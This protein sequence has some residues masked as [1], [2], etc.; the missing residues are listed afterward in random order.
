MTTRRLFL[1]KLASLAGFTLPCMIL[2]PSLFEKRVSRRKEWIAKARKELV[3]RGHPDRDMEAQ[4]Y[5]E[6]LF[7]D[8]GATH[9]PKLALARDLQP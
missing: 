8:Y 1:A 5:C 7:S 6:N 4:T 3:R 9:T 2:T